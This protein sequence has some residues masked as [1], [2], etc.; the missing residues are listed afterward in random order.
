MTA[1]ELGPGGRQG[2][3]EALRRQRGGTDGGGKGREKL[4][5]PEPVR[6]EDMVPCF[7]ERSHHPRWHRP[8]SGARCGDPADSFNPRAGALVAGASCSPQGT[9]TPFARCPLGVGV[10]EPGGPVR[11]PG[12]KSLPCGCLGWRPIPRVCGHTAWLWW[13]VGKIRTV[14]KIKGVGEDRPFLGHWEGGTAGYG[15]GCCSMRG[16]RMEGLGKGSSIPQAPCL[17]P[18]LLK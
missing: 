2:V 4:E 18:V 9:H 17:Q 1:I 6:R 5:P 14:A 3:P 13:F 12:G 8:A 11:V 16:W 10:G 15:G 7:P